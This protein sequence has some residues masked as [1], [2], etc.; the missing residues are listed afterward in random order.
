MRALM[1]V[2]AMLIDG[3]VGHPSNPETGRLVTTDAGRLAQAQNL[4]LKFVDKDGQQLFCR[5][6]FVTASR[7]RRDTT[8]YTADELD[9]L[10]AQQQ[11]DLDQMAVRSAAGGAH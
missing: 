1:L 8:C 9:K 6:N 5:S 3:C 2:A 7:I 4:N 10:E 11:H